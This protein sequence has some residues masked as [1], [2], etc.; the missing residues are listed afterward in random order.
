M[1][2]CLEHLVPLHAQAIN[3]DLHWLHHL[4]HELSTGQTHISV[5]VHGI[6]TS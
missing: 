3:Y 5:K 6:N 1:E 4:C 2:D